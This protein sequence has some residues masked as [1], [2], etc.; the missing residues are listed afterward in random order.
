MAGLSA[1]IIITTKNRKDEL[2][3]A[4]RSCLE[5][6]AR[7]RVLVIDDGST[8]GTSE[9]VRAEF[10][11]VQVDR[12]EQSLGLIGQRTRAASLTDADILISIDD[13][14]VFQSPRTVEQTLAEFDGN[15][16]I[17]AVAIPFVEPHKTGNF[18]PPRPPDDGR[19]HV[20]PHY[21]GC[22]HAIRRDVF[23]KLGGYRDVLFRQCEEVDYGMRLLAHGYVVRA[24][25]GDH[26]VHFESPRRDNKMQFFYTGRNNLL[27]GWWNVPFPQVLIRWASNHVNLMSFALKRRHPIWMLKGIAAAWWSV[28]TLRGQRRPMTPQAYRLFRR[29]VNSRIAPLD[30]IEP[31]LT[32]PPS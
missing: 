5:Q 30:E 9:M 8:D 22:A 20:V 32:P 18:P 26:I 28:L 13:D 27:V 23:L 19:L 2:R 1:T 4:L 7:P 16:R 10:P 11:T 24:G 6:T 12:S 21:I 3:T 25:R 14:A 17:A 31:G 15:P 29:M